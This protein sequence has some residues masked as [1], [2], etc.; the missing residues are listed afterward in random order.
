MNIQ[1]NTLVELAY[2]ILGPDGEVVE[3][4]EETEPLIFVQGD[5]EVPEGLEK[6][7]EGKAEGEAECDNE[8][9]D[10]GVQTVNGLVSDH[11]EM[12]S[13]MDKKTYG[14]STSRSYGKAKRRAAKEYDKYDDQRV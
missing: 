11:V 7:L 6:A 12:A 9:E 1:Q 10:D 3:S 14:A 2:I 8:K 5:G 13:A 4:S